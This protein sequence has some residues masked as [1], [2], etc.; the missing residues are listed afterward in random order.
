MMVMSLNPTNETVVNNIFY[1][2]QQNKTMA[3]AMQCEEV[4]FCFDGR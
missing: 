4:K 1:E 2:A 3:V